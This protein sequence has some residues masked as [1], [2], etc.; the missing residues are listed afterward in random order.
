MN[1]WELIERF[2][3][4]RDEAAF[5]DLV[6]RHGGFVLASARRQVGADLAEDVM[7][8]VF[9]VLA[10]KASALDSKVVLSSW[11]FRTTGFVV[12]Q[13]RRREARRIRREQ[14]AGAMIHDPGCPETDALREHVE[15][16]LDAAL[17]ALSDRDR[18]YVLSRFVE[19]Q[20][21]GDIG[22]R[23]G[24]SADAAKKRVLRG[25]ER[26]RRFLEGRGVVL[27]APVLSG[28][29]VAPQAEAVSPHLVKQI[30]DLVGVG[31]G[32]HLGGGVADLAEKAVRDW[33]SIG[34]RQLWVRLGMLAGTAALIGV[35]AS[36]GLHP[37]S[38][39]PTGN[40]VSAAFDSTVGLASGR[41]RNGSSRRSGL[42]ASLGLTLLD[43]A[44][45]EPVVGARVTVTTHPY[46]QPI[47][48]SE[49]VSGAGGGCEIQLDRRPD[50]YTKLWIRAPGFIPEQVGWN[51]Y[52]VGSQP[53]SYTCRLLPGR[54]FSGEIRG[55]QGE[56]VA[57]AR[58]EIGGSARRV[59]RGREEGDFEFAVKTDENGRF[60][61]D[62]FPRFRRLVLKEA[63]NQ[64]PLEN[65]VSIKVIAADY[66]PE[67][68]NLTNAL[69]LPDPW[70]ARLQR[71]ETLRGTVTDEA[72]V[73]IV[74]AR[75]FVI[76]RIEGGGGW[77][78][79]ASGVLTDSLGEFAH[80]NVD[81]SGGLGLNFYV[82][83]PE[84]SN[85]EGKVE[86]TDPA[87][88]R[89]PGAERAMQEPPLGTPLWAASQT[90]P[91][92]RPLPIEVVDPAGTG[93]ES[94]RVKVQLRPK[95]EE[96]MT[97]GER[98][99]QQAISGPPLHVIGKVVD[100]DSGLPVQQFR[101]L[102]WDTPGH[103]DGGFLG[104][105]HEGAF[106][107][108]VPKYLPR[109]MGFAVE[110]EG[111]QLA[112]PVRS[113]EIP[114][115]RSLLFELPPATELEGRVESPAGTPVVNAQVVLASEETFFDGN[116]GT[117]WQIGQAVGAETRSDNNG[118]FRLRRTG[119]EQAILVLHEEGCAIQPLEKGSG[120]I[121]RLERWA[122]VEGI[123][124]DG[125]LT[126]SGVTVRLAFNVRGPETPKL[127]C[128]C[129][130]AT[131]TDARGRFSFSHVPPGLCRISEDHSD[132]TVEITRGQVRQVQLQRD[133][134][135]RDAHPQSSPPGIP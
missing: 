21:F 89:L 122:K 114:D 99:A 118:A 134:N 110:A 106:D 30:S 116:A 51:W 69:Q 24:V 130:Q 4:R 32:S 1:D 101:V 27:S 52:E 55:P 3:A 65:I 103:G 96:Y 20:K 29:L 76:S 119:R 33:T 129:S 71:G 43:D 94:I 84:Y 88:F 107:W 66:V 36:S 81:A 75:V 91:R 8:A 10:R 19:G 26:V 73:P 98:E 54:P 100:S 86:K 131:K 25:L 77:G 34:W 41:G 111:Y 14:E 95:S 39:R 85:W 7:Q 2:V 37:P 63:G 12:A 61:T 113:E 15:Q 117:D 74:A 80:P 5:A 78:S 56:P 87:R 64:E 31:G 120:T 83:A 58:V 102:I 109:K 53:L 28:F 46:P 79:P 40:G 135:F 44:T 68:W 60:F 70:Q 67:G 93:L 23:F 124:M 104:E 121:I 115:G 57:G 35:T 97:V 50:A 126:I 17:S 108:I 6:R 38:A 125:E 123:V 127:R 112:R 18:G 59:S 11:L 62:E 48:G 16:H 22:E 13:V 9:L 47:G 45:G 49:F 82:Q 128:R 92:Y 132:R 133:I 42:G 72:G 105:G 90:A